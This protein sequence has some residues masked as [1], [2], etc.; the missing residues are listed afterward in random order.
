MCQSFFFYS[1]EGF[2]SS[3]FA[4]DLGAH[5]C[6]SVCMHYSTVDFIECVYVLSAAEPNRK[7][8]MKTNEKPDKMKNTI[9]SLC[10]CV[11]MVCTIFLSVK[12][13]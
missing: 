10:V 5:L 8:C 3:H 2:F 1:G 11:C 4:I 6:E 9:H 12:L 7:S 13:G